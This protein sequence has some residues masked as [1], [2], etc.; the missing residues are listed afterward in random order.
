VGGPG[1]IGAEIRD[2]SDGA[3]A[4]AGLPERARGVLISAVE[5]DGPAAK[6]GLRIGDLITAVNDTP[7]TNACRFEADILGREGGREVRLA[8]RRRQRALEK[9]VRLD[10]A[11]TF[12]SRACTADRGRGC[13]R[14]GVL[15]AVGKGVPRDPARAAQL[16]E[17]ACRLASAEGCAVAGHAR[18]E[19]TVAEKDDAAAL[20]LFTR[21]CD[22]GSAAG[23]AHLAFL[24]ATGT[25]VDNDDRK[26]TAL[27]EKSCEG[28]DARGAV[29]VDSVLRWCVRDTGGIAHEQHAR[30]DAGRRQHARVVAGSGGQHR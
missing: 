13:Y 22:A 11:V 1:T 3:L 12:Y 20:A 17:Q 21:A 6:A 30:G 9:T 4:A 15:H 2:P 8:F 23:C 24:Y 29:R 19:G 16:Y 25:E 5:G 14:L 18:L 10:D 7:V 28:G 26:A 27:Y